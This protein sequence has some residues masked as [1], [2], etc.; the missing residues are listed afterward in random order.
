MQDVVAKSLHQ[1]DPALWD[2]ALPAAMFAIN[3]TPHCETGESPHVLF[4]GRL[5][6]LPLALTKDLTGEISED[7]RFGTFRRI[8][9]KTADNMAKLQRDKHF[10]P[11][12]QVLV[13]RPAVAPGCPKKF[14][15]PWKGPFPVV[16]S[17]GFMK[18]VMK[19]GEKEF[20]AH[21]TQMKQYVEQQTPSAQ[22]P[23]TSEPVPNDVRSPNM[24]HARADVVSD[25]RRNQRYLM[26]P[27]VFKPTRLVNGNL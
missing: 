21:R 25:S 2:E 18:Y 9:E 15:L 14:S 7:D 16:R 11:G 26:R 17:C 1:N 5:S 20:L 12:N 8:Y 22:I 10:Q 27:R 24:L 19:D 6:R 23:R 4:F 13:Y 3:T